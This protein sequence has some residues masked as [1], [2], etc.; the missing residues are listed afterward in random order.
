MI[1]QKSTDN[2]CLLKNA[3]KYVK[4]ENIARKIS[5][6]ESKTKAQFINI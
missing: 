2:H 1:T 4:R 6:P 5:L 3:L